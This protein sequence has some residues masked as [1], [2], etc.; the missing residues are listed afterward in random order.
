VAALETALLVG[1]AAGVMDR[2][3]DAARRA[4]PASQPPDILDALVSLNTHGH[5]A[6]VPVLRQVLTGSDSGWTRV[7]GLAAV[8]A[9]ELWDL[10]LH[11]AVT[12]WLV[13]HGRDT[14]SP[15]TARIAQSQVAMGA[16]LTGDFGRAMA[17]IAEEEAI[18]D[19]L[20]D[21][22]Q[23]YPRVHL[24]ALRGRPAEALA[25]FAEAEDHGT[26]Q[27]AANVH[28]ARAVLYNGLGDYPAALEAAGKVTQAG[29]LFLAGAALPEVVEAATRCEDVGAAAAALASL[30][31]RAEAA[32]TDWA[33]GVL[34]GAQALV[35]GVEDDH[36]EAVQR[37]GDGPFGPYGARARLRYGEWLRREGRRR[38][39][40]EQLRS[41]H[42]QLSAIG[43]EAF[44]QRA[45]IELRATGEVVV[46]RSQHAYDRLTM[47]EMHIARHVAAGATSKEVAARL[48]LSPR[49]V[50][51]HLRNIFRKLG[52]T[53]R[54]QLR[55]MPGIG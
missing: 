16:V 7:P 35:S 1:R 6:G 34:A 42:E 2:V 33:K 14:G 26:G 52:I 12:E 20:G 21:V 23:M 49:T 39:A 30:A 10:P 9:G 38:D 25:L 15:L 3:L 28:W 36:R 32:D 29:D 46:N 8:L 4:P 13:R 54:R 45:A 43:M 27:L 53:S 11:T 48:Y 31:E 24:A 55:G 18:A 17:A 47:Q 44:A 50:E 41:A 51:T 22:P 5:R 40:R 19:A 37:L